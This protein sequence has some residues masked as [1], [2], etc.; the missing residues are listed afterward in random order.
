[1]EPSVELPLAR[2]S[3]LQ[4][5][6]AL[7]DRRRAHR[8]DTGACH[9]CALRQRFCICGAL[10][11]LTLPA[12]RRLSV[13]LVVAAVELGRSSSTHKLVSATLGAPTFVLDS[14][15]HGG[16]AASVWRAVSD[17]AAARGERVCVLFPSPTAVPFSS[18][19]SGGGTGSDG[20]TCVIALDA[21]WKVARRMRRSLELAAAADGVE[22]ASVRI[23]NA[24]AGC[25]SLF[26]A[27]R[28]Q[29][30]PLRV[31][32]L[33][34]VACCFDDDAAAR[35]LSRCEGDE[36]AAAWAEAA[37]AATVAP[38]EPEVE[39]EEEE[40]AKSCPEGFVQEGA[41]EGR[42][43]HPHDEVLPAAPSYV[44]R[45]LRLNLMLLADNVVRERGLASCEGHGRGAGY[46]TWS[47]PASEVGAGLGSLPAWLI[48]RIAVYAF[49][50][51][52]VL[53][54]G[55]GERHAVHSAGWAAIERRA[56]SVTAGAEAAAG[57]P[58]SMALRRHRR[59]CQGGLPPSSFFTANAL[60]LTN[61]YFFCLFAGTRKLEQTASSVAG[62]A[63]AA[64][65]AGA[66]E[67]P[68]GPR[69]AWGSAPAPA[70]VPAPA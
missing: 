53:A 16:G 42:A 68:I 3:R 47:L 58:S 19:A 43:L 48:E 33:E 61:S 57:A 34:A 9:S 69:S 59:L 49:G 55:Y 41:E 62:H 51:A 12:A 20:G 5:V 70:P 21:T 27:L 1:M 30:T 4:Q 56:A 13:V 28:R 8:V 15:A 22:L 29:P 26:Q 65:R 37:A 45:C 67:F 44:S 60:A 39:V 25:F 40:R 32:T 63:T 2:P 50:R 11:R 24:A 7:L 31:S 66:R 54:S 46:R 36:R 35:S 14:A 64:T 23:S 6:A 17:R 10:V 52:R 18:F 38:F